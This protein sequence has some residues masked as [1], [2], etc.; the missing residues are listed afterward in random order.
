MAVW[1]MPPAS[2]M[3]QRAMPTTASTAPTPDADGQ[4][5]P[6]PGLRASRGAAPPFRATCVP[7]AEAACTFSDMIIL[8][9]A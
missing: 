3:T 2:C 7:A 1:P 5:A 6:L 4:A 8:L 9:F